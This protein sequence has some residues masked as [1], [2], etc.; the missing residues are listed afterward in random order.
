MK[1]SAL[2]Y[3][4]L[5]FVILGAVLFGLDWQPATLSPMAP[6]QVVALPP[7]PPPPPPV[8]APK[9]AVQSSV[10]TSPAA[11]KVAAPRS[12]APRSAAP[13]S[14]APSPA[15]VAVA[16]VAPPAEAPKPLCDIAACTQAY[17]SFTASD[18]TYLSSTGRRLCTKGVVPTAAVTPAAPV[19][20]ASSDVPASIIQ[21]ERGAQPATPPAAPTDTQAGTPTGA[22]CNVSACATAY[23]TF[24]AS[25]CTFMASGGVRRLC[26]K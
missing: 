2:F 11:P 20:P 19:A 9:P 18:C 7:P 16:P 5:A 24:T 8:V 3:S 10:A 26:T 21:E 22:K 23:R 13:R 12:A 15:P 14:A 6:I 4:A 1:I 25:D 17:H